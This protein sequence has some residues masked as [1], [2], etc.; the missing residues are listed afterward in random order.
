MGQLQNFISFD[1]NK[2]SASKRI[3]NLYLC[4]YQ[5]GYMMLQYKKI[6][7]FLFLLVICMLFACSEEEPVKIYDSQIELA[8]T[9]VQEGK[10]YFLLDNGKTIFPDKQLDYDLTDNQRVRILFSIVQEKPATFEVTATI[11]S[12]IFI[13]VL[14][15]VPALQLSPEEEARLRNDSVGVESIWI[16]GHYLNFSFYIYADSKDHSINLLQTTSLEND[17]IRLEIRHNA[18]GDFPAFRKR[19]IVSFNIKDLERHK[20]VVLAIKAE[21]YSGKKVYYRNWGN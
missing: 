1:L 17:T 12:L 3:R 7:H 15:I 18:N 20:P 21:T 4:G 11:H 9:R 5:S 14:P 13:Q 10:P 16:G 8:T 2:K 19:G 6:F